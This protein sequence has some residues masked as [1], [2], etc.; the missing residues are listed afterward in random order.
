MAIE[1][2]RYRRVERHQIETLARATDPEFFNPATRAKAEGD[3]RQELEAKGYKYIAF[4]YNL[5]DEQVHVWGQ[6]PS[7]AVQKHGRQFKPYD[8][9]KG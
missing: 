4:R 8:P 7:N 5:P 6:H 1:M 9:R 3:K 2:T